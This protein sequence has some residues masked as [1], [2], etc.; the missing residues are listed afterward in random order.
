MESQ[1]EGEEGEGSL[2]AGCSQ[3]V[4]EA[5][6]LQRASDMAVGGRQPSFREVGGDQAEGTGGWEVETVQEGDSGRSLVLR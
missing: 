6:A 5:E 4:S 1:E 2:V 3:G